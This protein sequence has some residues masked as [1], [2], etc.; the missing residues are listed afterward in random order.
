MFCAGVCR[1][2]PAF[3][4]ARA[5][6]GLLAI[7]GP[8]IW[9]AQNPRPLFSRIVAEN[10]GQ[11]PPFPPENMFSGFFRGAAC[12][13]LAKAKLVWGGGEQGQTRHGGPVLKK[14]RDGALL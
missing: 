3:A 6:P 4:V 13:P 10:G 8:N 7:A 12:P 9:G 5:Y 1:R 11:G 2:L 14:A